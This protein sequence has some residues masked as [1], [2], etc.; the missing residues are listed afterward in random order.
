M[1]HRW[2]LPFLLTGD[3]NL[4][5]LPIFDVLLAIAL[6]VSNEITSIFEGFPIFG[7]LIKL[8]YDLLKI[9]QQNT[10]AH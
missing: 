1:A 9:T 2:K 7:A 8:N 6:F 5:G 4:P 10:L 3:K